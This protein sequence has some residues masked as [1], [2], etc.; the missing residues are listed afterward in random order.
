ML[1]TTCEVLDHVLQQVEGPKPQ[2]T[3]ISSSFHKSLGTCTVDVILQTTELADGIGR[4]FTRLFDE[5]GTT[6]LVSW[7]LR[8]Q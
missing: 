1:D 5:L 3:I 7:T 6:A 2:F 4:H 8:S